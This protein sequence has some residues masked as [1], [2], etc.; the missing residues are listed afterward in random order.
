[1]PIAYAD[2]LLF[3]LVV[4]ALWYGLFR[5]YAWLATRHERRENAE[6]IRQIESKLNN[7]DKR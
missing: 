6:L 5:L 2:V 3:V 1:M 7:K 4:A